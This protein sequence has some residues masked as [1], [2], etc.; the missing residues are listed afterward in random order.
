M[1]LYLFFLLLG[2]R[3]GV[4]PSEGVVSQLPLPGELCNP[5]APTLLVPL[6]FCTHGGSKSGKVG[7]VPTG[8]P[9]RVSST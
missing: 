5:P 2:V 3:V 1:S 7:R 6:V 9:N 4:L 8:L